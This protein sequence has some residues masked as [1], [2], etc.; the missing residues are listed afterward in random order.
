MGRID[1]EIEEEN[2]SKRS[3][4]PHSNSQFGRHHRGDKGSDT[5]S[6]MDD[7]L[8]LGSSEDEGSSID[9][10]EDDEERIIQ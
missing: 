3:R 1:E 2:K 4:V 10:G 5:H 6:R 7:D 8:S 9:G